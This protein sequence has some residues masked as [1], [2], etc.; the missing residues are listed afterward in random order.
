[1]IIKRDFF[2]GKFETIN[3]YKERFKNRISEVR[4]ANESS[5]L[6]MHIYINFS[7]RWKPIFWRII[8]H[9]CMETLN[10]WQF[11]NKL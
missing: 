7:S 6:K 11:K 8:K 1:M 9:L 4:F 2:R 3:L 10:K 5:K